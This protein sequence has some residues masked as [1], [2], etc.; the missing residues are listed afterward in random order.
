M[1]NLSVVV[2]AEIQK[3]QTKIFNE[4][5]RRGK[6]LSEVLRTAV[7]DELKGQ[8]SGR[9]Y[10]QRVK[11]RKITWQASAPGE[12]PAVRTGHLVNSN[13]SKVQAVRHGIGEGSVTAETRLNPAKKY[14]G[15]YNY[16]WI[17]QGNAKVDARPY[18]EKALKKA[19][20]QAKRIME[21]RYNV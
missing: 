18:T 7:N 16:A 12:A 6:G 14:G 21:R 1:K 3:A 4:V 9:V 20:E 19:T 8:R 5:I 15:S 11:G 17:D 13:L 10:S 2:Q